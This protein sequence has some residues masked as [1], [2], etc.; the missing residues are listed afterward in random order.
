MHGPTRYGCGNMSRWSTTITL[1]QCARALKEL[2]GNDRNGVGLSNIISHQQQDM[3]TSEN[4]LALDYK[5]WSGFLKTSWITSLWK[6]CSAHDI[7]ISGGWVHPRQR[8]HDQHLGDLTLKIPL[9][10]RKIIFKIIRTLNITTIADIATTKGTRIHPAILNAQR[11]PDR[12]TNIIWGNKQHHV[13]KTMLQKWR[14]FLCTFTNG[15]PI[16]KL[17][18]PL[19]KWIDSRYQT[20]S[21]WALPDLSVVVHN[22]KGATTYFTNNGETS[23]QPIVSKT[24]TVPTYDCKRLQRVDM[25]GQFCNSRQFWTCLGNGVRNEPITDKHNAKENS[26]LS[27]MTSFQGKHTSTDLHNLL[28]NKDTKLLIATDGVDKDGNNSF[29][30]IFYTDVN[31]SQE[32]ILSGYEPVDGESM[33]STRAEI[34]GPVAAMF[35]LHQLTVKHNTKII[36]DIIITLDNLHVARLAQR[37]LETCPNYNPSNKYQDLILEL[38]RLHERIGNPPPPPP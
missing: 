33:D 21:T 11:I 17:N 34:G 26:R 23:R 2:N 1:A 12:K 16:Y 22:E 30:I 37:W 24:N 38:K 25:I 3:A 20:F 28:Q 14:G 5:I 13:T 9:N 19:G 10:D 32:V 15:H 6:R 4:F 7:K 31:K 36:C 8:L 35:I 18:K 29:G 27:G